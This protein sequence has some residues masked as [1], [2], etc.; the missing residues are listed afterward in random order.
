VHKTA[1]TAYDGEVWA[2]TMIRLRVTC[3]ADTGKNVSICFDDLRYDPAGKAK[4]ILCFDDTY[5]NVYDNAKPKM[6]TNGQ[7]GVAFI[8]S[9]SVGGAGILTKAQLTTM[10]TAGWD[11]SNH[12]KTHMHIGGAGCSQVMME[13]EID[14]AHEWLVDN[15]FSDGARFFA[16]PYGEYNQAILT[17][18]GERHRI[19]RSII[20]GS[21][22]PHFDMF[23][24]DQDF[25]VK[26]R[27]P[28]SSIAPATVN[29]WIDDAITQKGLLVLI[30]HK[31]VASGAS[32]DNEY[33]KADFE[34]IS[35]YLKTKEDAV[36]INVI[37]FSDYYDQFIP[38]DPLSSKYDRVDLQ[39]GPV[40]PYPIAYEP[41]E[42]VGRAE[43]GKLKVYKHP[44]AGDRKRIWRIKCIADDSG[45]SGYKWRDLEYF[46]VKVVEGAKH[47]CV[48]VDANSVQHLVRIIDFS[49]KAI[50]L[51][52]R[53]EVTMILEEDYT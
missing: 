26:M 1:F 22:Q 24:D 5:A 13:E 18:V 37:T 15:G 34:T 27:Q 53:H 39:H 23:D 14:V 52:N 11:I 12:T 3:Q 45:A 9:N 46:Y 35:N 47:Q 21:Y 17:K 40:V 43:D 41:S 2:N 38:E 10:Q 48:F 4:C 42:G 7:A 16:Y 19:A 20:T 31:I 28:T 44:L 36:Q 51:N 8:C 32:G 6:D 50:G 30:F 29:G 25:L 49:P 33:N